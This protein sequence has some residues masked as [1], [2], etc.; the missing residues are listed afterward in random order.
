MSKKLRNSTG[1]QSPTKGEGDI[2][3]ISLK[4]LE[5]KTCL[6]RVMFKH[7]WAI[8]LWKSFV[9]GKIRSDG[10][11]WCYIWITSRKQGISV[12]I[13]FTLSYSMTF[14]FL[15][16]FYVTSHVP[17]F[18]YNCR[19]DVNLNIWK[20]NIFFIYFPLEVDQSVHGK[21]L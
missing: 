20:V 2:N 5:T 1:T 7:F 13:A 6:G 21:N 12:K 10:V 9:S 17:S 8:A 11:C 16:N 19:G 4:R 3:T 14:L 15:Y 18:L